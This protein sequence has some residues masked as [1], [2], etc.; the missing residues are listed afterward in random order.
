MNTPAN[1]F[2][3]RKTRLLFIL[4]LL[5]CCEAG[6]ALPLPDV[7]KPPS[8][9]NLGSTSFYDGFGRLRPGV[10]VLTYFRWSDNTEISTA[11]GVENP[12]F[13]APHITVFSAVTQVIVASRWHPFGGTA[14]FSV[15]APFVDVQASFAPNSP[16][17]LSTNGFGVGDIIAGPGYQSRYFFRGTV[18]ALLGRRTPRGSNQPAP[19][20]G[21][22]AQLVVQIP[23][24][25]LNAAKSI[26]QGSGYWAVVPYIAAAYLPRPRFET[27]TRLHYEYNLPTQKIS[28]PP[29]ISHLIYRS[30]QAGQ[31]VYGNYTDSYRFTRNLYLGSNMYAVYQLSPDKTNGVK[32][33]KAR[34]TQIFEGPGGGYD[35]SPADTLN[36]NLYLKVEAHNTADGPSLQ[37]LYIHRF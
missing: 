18:P 12:I 33:G 10:T 9:I 8:G 36:I 13:V 23:T 14:G 1:L 32:V 30:G 2:P 27:S 22:R 24:G 19:Y 29:L 25:R 7:V 26:N 34:E 16:K 3:A 35:F 20:F 21:F 6:T 37:L 17:T 15:L 28:D 5:L 31:L 11:S 4:A